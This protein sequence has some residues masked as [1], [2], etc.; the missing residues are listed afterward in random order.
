MDASTR[1]LKTPELVCLIFQFDALTSKDFR[2]CML[3]CSTWYSPAMAALWRHLRTLEPLLY[4]V[5]AESRQWSFRT[6]RYRGGHILTRQARLGLQLTEEQC[7]EVIL[8]SKNI[9]H[10]TLRYR[11]SAF[12]M[13]IL[14]AFVARVGLEALLPRLRTITIVPPPDLK[15]VEFLPYFPPTLD[16]HWDLQTSFDINQIISLFPNQSTFYVQGRV[17]HSD[18]LRALHIRGVPTITLISV[19]LSRHAWAVEELCVELDYNTPTVAL[20]VLLLST[21]RGCANLRRLFIQAD[22]LEDY[23]T[24]KLTQEVMQYLGRWSELVD[25]RIE[26]PLYSQLSDADWKALASCWPVMQSLCIVPGTDT[27]WYDLTGFTLPSSGAAPACTLNAVLDIACACPCLRKLELPGVNCRLLP[28]S[29][30]VQEVAALGVRQGSGRL[31]QEMTIY[32]SPLRDPA[33]L[34]QILHLVFPN[35]RTLYY[36][37]LPYE[38]DG[39]SDEFEPARWDSVN[40]HLG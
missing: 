3:V 17:G 9:R 32:D 39:T 15:Q 22:E 29:A 28:T 18:Y 38:E 31:L 35:L 36:K 26:A 6:R 21:V 37:Q 11:K 12:D 25:L 34:G 4:V 30:R 13:A 1:V 40:E 24:W 19:I 5:P 16:R 33:A 7:D 14:T 10:L 2:A 27:A 20:D 23:D 8:H